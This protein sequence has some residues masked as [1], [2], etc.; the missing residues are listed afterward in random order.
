MN[1]TLRLKGTLNYKKNSNRPGSPRLPKNGVVTSNHLKKLRSQLQRLLNFWEKEDLFEG[2]LLSIYYKG[3]IA[4]SN[5][6]KAYIK[7]KSSSPND[8]IVGA[9]F[10]G[11]KKKHV[12]THLV[13]LDLIRSDIENLNIV[14]QNI[15]E[16]FSGEVTYDIINQVN[17]EEIGLKGINKNKFS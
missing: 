15:D 1:D 12:I 11:K 8:T 2:A 6:I 10:H 17:N 3:V 7:Q 14:I 9:R 5:R 4:K 13:Y 16:N